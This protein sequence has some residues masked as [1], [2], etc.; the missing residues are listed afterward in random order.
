MLHSLCMLAIGL[1]GFILGMKWMRSGLEQLAVGRLPEILK[2]FVNT[3]TKGLFTGL[4]VSVLMQSSGAVTVI[5]IG[6]VSVGTLTFA[7]SIGIILGANVG[8]TVTAQMIALDFD[9]FALPIIGIGLAMRIL[10]KKP[11]RQIGQAFFGFGTLFA[12]LSLMTVALQPL[13]R[14]DWFMNI[15]QT[16]ASNPLLGVAAG[17]LLTALVQSSSAT[18]ALTIA[19]A[20][21]HLVSLDGAVAI[22]LGN[23]IGSCITAIIAAIGNPIPARQVAMAHVVLNVLGVALFLPFI[24]PFSEL[25]RLLAPTV[26]LQVAMSHTLFNVLSSLIVW[27]FARPFARLIE[28]LVPDPA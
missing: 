26:A 20:T 9:R 7:D 3:P 1:Y 22:V 28:W 11:F 4:V 2:R 25:N 21:E 16:S 10:C 17:A 23:N 6:L 19:L 27:P 8:T 14:S 15:L 5:T 18:T 12:C 13:A 24:D